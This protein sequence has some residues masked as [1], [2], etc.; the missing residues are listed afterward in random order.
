[1]AR[2]TTPTT[3][4]PPPT[5]GRPHPFPGAWCVQRK[6][7][8]REA[9][10]TVATALA[11]KGVAADVSHMRGAQSRMSPARGRWCGHTSHPLAK[12]QL[13]QEYELPK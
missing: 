8:E 11:H 6:A 3:R 13:V 1:M 10:T 2:A 5:P 4:T 9:M 12:G 7:G